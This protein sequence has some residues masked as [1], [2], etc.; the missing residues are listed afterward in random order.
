MLQHVEATAIQGVDHQ[1]Q[2][3]HGLGAAHDTTAAHDGISP[4]KT[5]HAG[6][7][8]MAVPVDIFSF[9]KR[10]TVSSRANLFNS[11]TYFLLGAM[12]KTTKKRKKYR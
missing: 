6:K 7:G 1:L 10:H 5:A 12:V 9:V 4:E 8:Q 11:I 2:Q 3:V